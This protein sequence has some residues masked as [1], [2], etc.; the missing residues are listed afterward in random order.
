MPSIRRPEEKNFHGQAGPPELPHE[1]WLRITSFLD[2]K[3]RRGLYS[4]NKPLFSIAM[5][6]RY[7]Y[8]MIGWNIMTSGFPR[9]EIR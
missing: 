6:E 9:V 7:K 1:I 2:Y 5:N 8:A 4:V 3:T